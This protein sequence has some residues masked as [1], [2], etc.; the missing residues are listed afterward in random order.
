MIKDDIMTEGSRQEVSQGG[1][2]GGH[3][4][5]VS[6][7]ALLVPAVPRAESQGEA[8]TQVEAHHL[9]ELRGKEEL[10]WH[11]LLTLIFIFLCLNF[12]LSRK[13]NIALSYVTINSST[14]Q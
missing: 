4:V 7:H 3:L 9:H 1:I 6:I 13:H 10:R 8:H 11:V 2:E 12:L 14:P 5:D